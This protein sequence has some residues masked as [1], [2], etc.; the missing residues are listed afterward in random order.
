MRNHF[1]QS[2]ARYV[3]TMISPKNLQW[4]LADQTVKIHIRYYRSDG[5]LFGDPVIEYE[6]PQDW[7]YA[8]LWNGW[9]WVEA[10]KWPEDHYRVEL[11]LENREK[12]GE[13][14]FTIH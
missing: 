12:I 9:G 4:Q 7:E 1:K 6:I 2:S 8:E 10:G 3:F 14:S 5:R 13:S 11:W